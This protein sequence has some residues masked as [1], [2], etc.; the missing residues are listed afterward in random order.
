MPPIPDGPDVA[1]ALM[2][3][4]P[5]AIDA[6]VGPVSESET[7]WLSTFRYSTSELQSGPPVAGLYEALCARSAS[8]TPRA[9]VGIVVLVSSVA[10]TKKSCGLFGAWFGSH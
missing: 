5:A 7:G 10:P 9:L 6:S 8:W 3:C 2:Y 4:V 1:V